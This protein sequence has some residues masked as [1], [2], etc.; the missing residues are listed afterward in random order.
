MPNNNPDFQ[1]RYR[2]LQQQ[3]CADLP[4]RLEHILTAGNSWLASG[5][6]AVSGDEFLTSVHSLAGSAGSFGFPEI[7]R[8]CQ[9]IE[10]ALREN[11]PAS[12]ETVRTC[13][14]QLQSF[15]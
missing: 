3:F 10:D 14:D 8:L 2:V 13:L 7:T 11:R 15:I 12:K 6:Q 4:A 1:A 9:R 5:T